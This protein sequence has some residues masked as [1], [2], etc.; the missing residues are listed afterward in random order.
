MPPMANHKTKLELN[1]IGKEIGGISRGG[2]ETRSGGTGV[3]GQDT[4]NGG[5]GG[6]SRGG[7]EIAEEKHDG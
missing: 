7:A 3:G 6:I 4:K 2:A 1:W 5:N